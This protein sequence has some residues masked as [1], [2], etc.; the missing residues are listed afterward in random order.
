[1]PFGPGC[2]HSL[3]FSVF[4]TLYSPFGA[5]EVALTQH[6]PSDGRQVPPWTVLSTSHE[7]RLSQRRI[8]LLS[9]SLL[10]GCL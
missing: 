6:I 5:M 7:H 8:A 4:L 3:S 10:L 1:M 2:S 9:L